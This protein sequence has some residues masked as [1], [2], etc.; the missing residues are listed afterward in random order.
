[1]IIVGIGGCDRCKVYKK[2][3]PEY[4]YIMLQRNVMPS[5]SNILKIKKALKKLNFDFQFPVLLNKELTK[6]ISY[7]EIKDEISNESKKDKK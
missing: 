1:M 4:E 2:L 6:L 5:N 7:S 3:H